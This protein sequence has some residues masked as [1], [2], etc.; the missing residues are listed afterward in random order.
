[1][2]WILKERWLWI[3]IGS[4]ITVLIGSFLIVWLLL[5][6]PEWARITLTFAIVI[7]WGVAA[8]YK[9]WILDKEKREEENKKFIS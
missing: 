2:A 5:Y 3:I 7:G 1:V 8:G 4:L 9:D 6:L